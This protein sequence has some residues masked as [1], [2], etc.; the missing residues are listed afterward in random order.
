MLLFDIETDGLLDELTTVHMLCAVDTET[1]HTWA[2]T[3]LAK[4]EWFV[5]TYLS[6]EADRPV[7]FGGHNIIGFDLPALQKVFPGFKP[8]AE[9]ID[10]L[11]LSRLIY[12][13]LMESDTKL[14]EAGKLPKRFTGS[15]SLEAWGYRL[16]NYKGDYQGPWSSKECAPDEWAKHLA[17]MLDYCKQD[18]RVTHKLY[19]KLTEQEYAKE[20]VTLEHEVQRIVQRQIRYGVCFDVGKAQALYADLLV[21]RDEVVRELVQVFG[22][23]FEGDGVFTP[24]RDNATLGYLAGVPFTKVKQVT[25][26]PGSRQHIARCLKHLYG[27]SPKSF[28]ETGLAEINE[29]VLEGLDYPEAVLLKEYFLLDKRLGQLADGQ[30]GW[31]KKVSPAGRIHGNVNT[32]GAVTGRMTH[33]GPN[34]AQVPSNGAP[35][36]S[37]CRELFKA[38]EGKVMV[39]VDASSLEGRTLGHYASRYDGGEYAKILLEGDVHWENTQALGLVPRGTLRDKHNEEHEAKRAIAKTWFYAWLYGAGDKKL[40]TTLGVSE[41]K[42]KSLRASFLKNAKALG[43]LQEDIARVVKDKGYLKGID[44]RVLRVR[45]EHSALNTLLQSCGALIMKRGLVILDKTLQAAGYIPGVDYEF[46]LN[47]HDEWQIETHEA[48]AESIKETAINAIR[49][50]GRYYKCRVPMEGDGKVGR[51]WSETH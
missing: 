48:L 32:N 17:D 14:T 23:W 28:T 49:Q 19:L 46:L 50:A 29:K 7:P 12:S 1:Q 2:L 40:A 5:K 42:A 16:G 26:N 21:R 9:H 10:T 39:G 3:D 11:V 43:M 20:A 22:S 34:L 27:W 38:S 33:S 18:V 4:I 41:A 31:L 36:G 51:N 13:D 15:H 37:R 6:L 30:A 25:F 24:K 44:G 8:H 45:S 47:V 35:Y